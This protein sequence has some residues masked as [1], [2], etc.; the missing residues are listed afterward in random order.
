MSHRLDPSIVRAYDIRGVVGATLGEEDARAVGNAFAAEVRKRTESC[1]VV[2]ER[3]GR[4][5][6]PGLEEALI[7]GLVLAGAKVVRIGVGPT[8]MAH[9]AEATNDADAV[10]V[11]TGSHN[12]P[13]HNGFKFAVG[14]A[15]FFGEDLVGLARRVEYGSIVTDGGRATVRQVADGYVKRLQEE[16]EAMKRPFRVAWD[17]GHGAAAAV[18]SKLVAGL[19]GEH[20]LLNAEVDGTFPSHH[21]DPSV[22]ANMCEL[23]QNVSEKGL[24]LGF[25]FDGD[26]DRLGVIDD[27]GRIVSPDHLLCVFAEDVL[28]GTP[29]ATVLS[30]VKAS[31]V[32]FQHVTMLGG[33]P[34][35]GATGHSH[36]RQRILSG[37]AVFAGEVSGHLFFADRYYGFDDAL[38]AAV[39]LLVALGTGASLSARC[40]ALP[41][42][43][44]TSEIRIG[45]A[46]ERKFAVVDEVRKGLARTGADVETV[47]GVRV[48]TLDGWWLL[49]ASNTE[50]ALVV[51]C[52]GKDQTALAKLRDTLR[53]MLLGAG[54]DAKD[55]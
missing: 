19:P 7:D 28:E 10:V 8:A 22:P 45:C 2:V 52:E 13:D 11:V 44:G 51:R 20:V 5:S 26:G 3:D 31:D 14:G 16:A 30:D 42:L 35:M 38:Y 39:R 32:L 18:M 25:A 23:S 53:K 21:P 15:P 27:L 41:R 33:K 1:R 34:L 46:D 55:V 12:P 24:D 54:V 37:D 50:P 48:R 29:G 4:L 36:M 47:D 17:A 40:D 49:R 6:S 43:A 9:F